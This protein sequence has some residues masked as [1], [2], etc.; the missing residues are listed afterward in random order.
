MKPLFLFLLSLCI[1]LLLPAQI[2]LDGYKQSEIN[3]ALSE[4]RWQARWISLPNEPAN[5]YGVY[6][7]RK[8]FELDDVAAKF[9]VHVSADNRY[10]L[11]VNGRFASLGPARGDVYNW[12]FET[13]DIAP[14]LKKGRNTLAAVVWNYAGLK[15]VAQISFNQTGFILQ[16]NT[17]A[18]ALVN[19]DHSWRCIRNEA[20][21]PWNEWTV[22]GYYAAGPGE[23]INMAAYPQ[24]WEKPEY[25]DGHWENARNGIEGAMKGARD[26][27]G[28]LLVP[29]PIPPMEMTVERLA[30]LVAVER[31][32]GA[33]VSAEIICPESFPKSTAPVVIPANQS[34]RLLLDNQQLTTGYLSL[35]F[36]GGKDAEVRIGYAEALYENNSVATTKSYNLNEK[37]HRDDVKGKLFVGYEDKLIADGGE[38]RLFTSL[39]WRTWRY[40]ELRITTAAEP[41]TLDD[42]YATF[43]AYPFR[44][45]Y[46][47]SAPGH[48]EL[49]KMLDIGW[50]TARLCANETYMDCPY[51]EQL[52]YF[53]DTRIQAMIT[54]FNTRDTYMVKHALEQGRRSI[55]PDGITMSRYPSGLHQFIP[56]FSLW[57]ICMGH[58]FW[59]YRGEE[60]YLRSLLPS[61]RGIIS[62]YERLLKA[63]N[64]LG[65]VPEW[66]FADWSAGF[67]NGEPV[68]EKEGNSAFQDLIY[69][70]A[71]DAASEMEEAFGMPSLSQHYRN[72]AGRIRDSIRSKYWNGERGLF[73][74]THDHRA[75]SQHVNALVVLA[76]ILTR[77]EAA[78]LMERT[79]ADKDIAQATIYFRYYVHQAMNKAGLGDLL[80]GNLQ[81]WRDQMALGLT[82][83]AEMPEPSRSDC[84]AWGASPNIEFFRILLGIDSHAPGFRKIRIS[85]S[86]GELKNVSGTMPHPTGSISVSY[87]LDKKGILKAHIILPPETTG[88]FVWKGKE[89]ALTAGEQTLTAGKHLPLD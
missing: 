24:G 79:L 58:D 57:W 85:P 45:E 74:D 67:P 89:Y 80:L 75:Y 68:R 61:F 20:Y 32:S 15:P 86:L 16:G 50:R 42:I 55:V 25:N 4:G 27:P 83:W 70:L 76:G 78:Q 36:S 9:V 88:T 69:I 10:K 6:H 77:Q 52:Q 31:L 30:N 26:Y 84:H 73:A 37:N 41:L 54:L 59:R 44:D 40:V 21:R 82:T 53:G 22:P 62:W 14:F 17:E 71:L 72:L 5:V 19:T 3:P 7:F 46:T 87:A 35:L 8:S 66:F 2:R 23:W 60:A 56:S 47:F 18:E 63:D 38:R 81:I 39:W 48:P 34:V 29:T 33:G 64:S 65:Y 28:R 12:N 51:Y 43:S 49:N 11:Y 1:P 13:V